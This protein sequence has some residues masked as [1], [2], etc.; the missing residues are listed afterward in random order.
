MSSRTSA[1]RSA[2]RRAVTGTASAACCRGRAAPANLEARCCATTLPLRPCAGEHEHGEVVLARA[3]G[4]ERDQR[5]DDR[6]RA[7]ATSSGRAECLAVEVRTRIAEAVAV[8]HQRVAGLQ[9]DHAFLIVLRWVDA[10]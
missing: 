5:V 1:R 9:A 3:G 10:E 2:Q 6:G 8:D 7:A 4:R